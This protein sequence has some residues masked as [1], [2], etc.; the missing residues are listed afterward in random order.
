MQ[1]TLYCNMQNFNLYIKT[2]YHLLTLQ[3]NPITFEQ[4]CTQVSLSESTLWHYNKRIAQ[5][6]IFIMIAIVSVPRIYVCVLC[7]VVGSLHIRVNHVYRFDKLYRA[8]LYIVTIRLL[9]SVAFIHQEDAVLL[10]S[11]YPQDGVFLVNRGPDV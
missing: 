8:L 1:E 7:F 2:K 5:C 10:E 11:L 3:K 6:I 4:S 9:S